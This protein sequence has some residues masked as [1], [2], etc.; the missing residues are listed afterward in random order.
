MLTYHAVCAWVH[1]GR[2][3]T[4]LSSLTSLEMPPCSKRQNTS[5]SE[6]NLIRMTDEELSEP[7]TETERPD[8]QEEE[9]ETGLDA[10]IQAYSTLALIPNS[11]VGNGGRRRVAKG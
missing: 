11:P 5:A 3:V 9:E 7:P 10:F 8:S 2:V 1:S 6:M 4:L